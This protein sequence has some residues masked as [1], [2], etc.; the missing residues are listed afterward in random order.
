MPKFIVIDENYCLYSTDDPEVAKKIA[1]HFI[2]YNIE[3]GERI[4]EPGDKIIPIE[5]SVWKE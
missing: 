4:D 3:T 2:V 5:D 1:E